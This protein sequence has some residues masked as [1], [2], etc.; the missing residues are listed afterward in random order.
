MNSTRQRWGQVLGCTRQLTNNATVIIIA[1]VFA[2]LPIIFYVASKFFV[3]RKEFKLMI[4][5]KV[6]LI[7]RAVAWGFR[8]G[9]QEFR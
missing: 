8:L 9:G 2:T 1:V 6:Q 5:K 4:R 7:C 3:G